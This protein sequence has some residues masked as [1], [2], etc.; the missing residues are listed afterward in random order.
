V[1]V[2]DL[3]Y[4]TPARRKFLKSPRTEAEQAE[5]ALRRLALA[6]PHTAFRLMVED[7]VAFDLPAQD[8]A[9][10][11]AALLGPE[12]A[13]VL[14]QVEGEREGAT[15]SGFIAAPSVTRA[16]A[17]GQSLVVNGRPV[18]DPTLRTALR[19]AYRNVIEP[20]RYPVAA[21]WLDLPPEELDVNVHP[22]KTE[23]R[24]RQADNIRAL[25]IGTLQRALGGGA[26]SAAPRANFA[27]PLRLQSYRSAPRHTG[28]AEAQLPFAAP[29]A[30]RPLPALATPVA[31]HPL[32]APVA[33]V[34]D[35]YIIAAT[36]DDAVILVDQHAAH[37]RLMH[38][39]LRAQL[40]A[41][42]V[43]SQP[44]LL[45]AVID[46]SHEDAARLA[47]AAPAL[48]RLG[49]ELED[50]GAG[51]ILVRALPAALGAAD[52]A[53]LIRDI[54]DEL[55]DGGETTALDTKLD[56]VIARMACHGSIRAGRRLA[57]PEM[58]ALL[59]QMEATPRAATCSHGRPTF[60]KLTKAEIEKLFGRR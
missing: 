25:V 58:D 38:E 16:N 50:F 33:Q 41:G 57:L 44:L 26:G 48:A 7:R 24:F 17:G 51:A 60:L 42:G 49:L 35:T 1:T 29:P 21:L 43:H 19:V 52:P 47:E 54:A 14:M 11:C 3:F 10:R 59:R 15:L 53:P 13:P 28:F 8:R 5:A 22:A 23:L 31:A 56:A 55:A 6:A 36:A 30:F 9:A 12:A 20:G 45:P 32:G 40:L 37:E 4:A 2:E 34:L 39:A 46:L 18:T 27:P